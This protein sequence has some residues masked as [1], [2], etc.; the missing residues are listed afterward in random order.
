[1]HFYFITGTSSGI[2][3]ALAEQ[4]LIREDVRVYGISRT[5]TII[6]T[7]YQHVFADLSDSTQFNQIYLLFQNAYQ[8]TD[9]VYLIN[10]S[11]IIEPIKYAGDFSEREIQELVQVNLIASIQLINAFL[12]IPSTDFLTRIILNI[13]SG[14]A[15]KVIDGWSLYGATKAALDHFSMH[16][17]KEQMIKGEGKT[18]VFSVAPGV[19]DTPMQEKIRHAAEENFSTVKRFNQ[20]K[21][22]N[23]L[24]SASIISEKYL[25]IL[26]CP[27]DFP[28][29]IFSVRDIN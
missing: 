19:V 28:T 12:K 23:E 26:D 11:G 17:A 5:C 22:D 2:G 24:V 29:V 18:V 6:H 10:N 20:L 3:K 1:M 16:V 21:K 7:N 9:S 14:A 13:S 4:L 27:Q 25:R 8:P 15:T